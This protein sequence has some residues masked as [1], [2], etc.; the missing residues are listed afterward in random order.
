MY[1]TVF[2]LLVSV[3]LFLGRFDM[4]TMQVMLA[5]MLC[6]M[7]AYHA[8]IAC[9]HAMPYACVPCRSCLLS[10]HAVCMQD[11]CYACMLNQQNWVLVMSPA[12]WLL[13]LASLS[14]KTVH[15]AA[16]AAYYAMVS[17]HIS[18]P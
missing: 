10:C 5:A 1:R 2:D 4:R 9:C 16:A 13:E 7:H 12:A 17:L 11:S 8:G 14:C 6:R 15:E 18:S 3:K